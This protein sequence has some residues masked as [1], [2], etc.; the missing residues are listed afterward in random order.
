[1]RILIFL[2]INPDREIPQKFDNSKNFCYTV[3]QFE[4]S[5]LT[6]KYHKIQCIVCL[7]S[8]VCLSGYKKH[9]VSQDAPAPLTYAEEELAM[10]K[11]TE[12][13]WYRY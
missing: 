10:I 7:Q 8:D 3:T 5:V 11:Q 13:S 1:M 9:L 4:I 2:W 12:V 6:L